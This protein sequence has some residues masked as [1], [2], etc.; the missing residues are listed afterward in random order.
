M[1]TRTVYMQHLQF[2]ELHSVLIDLT[3][4]ERLY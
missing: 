4:R 3:L 1:E 2:S